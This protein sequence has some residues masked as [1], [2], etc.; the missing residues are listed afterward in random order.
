VDASGEVRDWWTPADLAAWNALGQRVA[1]QYG[2]YSVPGLG[3]TKVNGQLTMDS[4]VADISGVELAWDAFNTGQPSATA[5]NRKTFFRNWSELWAQRLSEAEATH[6]VSTDVRA[7][8]QWRSNGPLANQPGFSQ[9]FG[10][11]A[12]Q[13]MRRSDADQIKVWQ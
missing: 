3:K 13:P 5:D 7:P 6:R 4:N 8:G 10:C 12:G 11:R 2:S 1:Q 9:A